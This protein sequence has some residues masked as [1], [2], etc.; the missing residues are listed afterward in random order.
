MLAKT[1]FALALVL[2]TASASLAAPKHHTPTPVTSAQTV[3]NP[4]GAA[5]TDPD[6]TVRFDLKRDWSHGRY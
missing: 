6:A 3:Y 4:A 1:S 5:V 2:A